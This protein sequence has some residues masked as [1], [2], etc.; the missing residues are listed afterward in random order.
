MLR[1]HFGGFALAAASALC[2]GCSPLRVVNALVPGSGYTRSRAVAY[3]ASPREQLDVYVPAKAALQRR[4]P[5]SSTAETGTAGNRSDYLFAGEALASR[6]IVAVIPDYRLYPEVRFPDFLED[7]A[8]AVRWTVDHAARYARTRS[9]F[10]SWGIRPALTTPRCSPSNPA[11]LRRAGRSTA[12][13]RGLIGLAGPY[14]FLPLQSDLTKGVFGFPDTSRATQPIE[15]ATRES[16]AALLVDR[17]DDDVVDPGNSARLADAPARAPARRCARSSIPDVGHARSSAPCRAAAAARP[18]A[19]RRRFV[20]ERAADPRIVIPTRITGPVGPPVGEPPAGS[21]LIASFAPGTSAA[22]ARAQPARARRGCPAPR[23]KAARRL[24]RAAATARSSAR[25]R[26]ER[27]ARRC[28]SSV[29]RSLRS[30]AVTRADSALP[31]SCAISHRRGLGR[32]GPQEL[33]SRCRTRAPRSP[34][35]PSR[36]RTRGAG[37]RAC[38][39]ARA[40]ARARAASSVCG[41]GCDFDHVR[42]PR[43]EDALPV[44]EPQRDAR[45]FAQRALEAPARRAAQRAQQIFAAQAHRAPGLR[46]ASSAD[47]HA[48]TRRTGAGC[49]CRGAPSV[50]TVPSGFCRCAARSPWLKAVLVGE[51]E[52]LPLDRLQP[53]EAVAQPSATA[54]AGLRLVRA[55][56]PVEKA[57]ERAIGIVVQRVVV[58]VDARDIVARLHVDRAVAHDRDHPGDGLRRERVKASAVRQMAAKASCRTSSATSRRPTTRC[59]T[60]SRSGAHSL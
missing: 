21:T 36:A 6:G 41:E 54:R 20:R 50:L 18:G 19:G 46:R 27:A 4:W 2:A 23:A 5:Y 12:R 48:A 30:A 22:S 55:R 47:P 52:R 51:H 1:R 45:L 31:S 42:V 7:C 26:H 43:R 44:F 9:A 49:P 28:S 56:A 32:H 60:P 24:P 38:G 29:L 17:R 10:S 15:F 16:A 39:S 3:G 58:R 53:R 33:R 37:A 34:P 13:I 14:D 40:R 8:R 57:V 11:Y 59:A 25:A 35:P